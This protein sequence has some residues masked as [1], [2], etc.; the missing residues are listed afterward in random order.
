MSELYRSINLE[1][2]GYYNCVQRDSCYIILTINDYKHVQLKQTEVCA[3][4]R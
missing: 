2:L 1:R 3:N 4:T